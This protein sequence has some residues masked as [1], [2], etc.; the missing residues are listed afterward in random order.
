MHPEHG[1]STTPWQALLGAVAHVP[2]IPAGVRQ[3]RRRAGG[4]PG[5][6]VSQDEEYGKGRG[7]RSLQVG[8]S[9]LSGSQ[10]VNVRDRF[11]VY[12]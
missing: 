2:G 7:A 1:G 12:L 6:F 5:R 11:F 10:E 3:E 8:Q 4:L 9:G